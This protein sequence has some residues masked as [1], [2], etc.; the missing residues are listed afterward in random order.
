MTYDIEI[1]LFFYDQIFGCKNVSFVTKNTFDCQNFD[2]DLK[3]ADKQKS[4][5]KFVRLQQTSDL[6][7]NV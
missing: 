1:P 7:P 2:A 5:T 3:Q 4:A 6:L